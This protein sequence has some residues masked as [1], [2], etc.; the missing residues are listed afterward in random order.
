[1]LVRLDK[2][3]N[4]LAD[5]F[6]SARPSV[7]RALKEMEEEGYLEAKGKNIRIFDKEGLADLTID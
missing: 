2:T 4:D 5:F 1:V 3:Q 7:A 6:G